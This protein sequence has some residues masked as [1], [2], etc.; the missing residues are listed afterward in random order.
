MLISKQAECRTFLS[1]YSFMTKTWSALSDHAYSACLT[2]N[3]D[4]RPSAYMLTAVS[5][6]HPGN[7][8]V[9]NPEPF[10][11]L[12][13]TAEGE[14]GTQTV[15]AHLSLKHRWGWFEPG[16]LSVIVKDRAR[17]ERV[18]IHTDETLINYFYYVFS[19]SYFVTSTNNTQVIKMLH[20]VR[21]PSSAALTF[22]CNKTFFIVYP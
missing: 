20:L 8:C 16:W 7:D 18:Q 5:H 2:R 6:P 3:N 19:V 4:G 9:I 14:N 22:C 11:K 15:S 21:H 17:M 13:L 1:C 12:L 10:F